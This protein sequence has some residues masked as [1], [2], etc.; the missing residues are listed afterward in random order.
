MTRKTNSQT[1][2]FVKAARDL[3]CSEDEKAF[4]QTLKKL[5]ST[6][7]PKSVQKRKLKQAAHSS[8]CA[9]HNLPAYEP[10]DCDCG[11]EI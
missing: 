5:G 3:G 9:V 6:P 4:D 2:L 1:K 10:G 11:A 7:P 8:G